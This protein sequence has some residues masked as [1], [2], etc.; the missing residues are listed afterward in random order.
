MAWSRLISSLAAAFVK[1]ATM[2]DSAPNCSAAIVICFDVYV[3]FPVPGGP[4]TRVSFIF[5]RVPLKFLHPGHKA[6]CR[7]V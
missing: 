5:I 6:G 2:I 3:V 4:K 1:L 7:F